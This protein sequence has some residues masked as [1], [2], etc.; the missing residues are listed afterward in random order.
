V[1]FDLNAETTKILDYVDFFV[2]LIFLVDFACQLAKADDRWHYFRTWG[3][4][5]LVSSIPMLDICRWGRAARIFRI[6]RVLRALRAT[7]ILSSF[8]LEQRAQCALWA[9]SLLAILVTV[10]SSIAILQLESP[11]E[12]NIV[13]A[14]DALWWAFV[15]MT[16]VGYGDH[17]PVTAFGRVLAAF[18]MITGIGLFGTF[19]AYVA[20]SFLAPGEVDQERELA[21]IRQELQRLRESLPSSEEEPSE[22]T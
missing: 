5:D 3:W 20:A 7:R 12:A 10:F 2:S 13:S 19:T 15:T 21:A 17:Y 1:M 4:I 11:G 9:A 14:E 6:L 8:V 18:L 22:R 16:T